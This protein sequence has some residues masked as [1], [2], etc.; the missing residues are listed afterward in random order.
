M[1]RAAQQGRP[2]ALTVARRASLVWLAMLGSAFVNGA[3]R[4]VVLM[5]T[6]ALPESRAQRVS[7]F[8]G[9]VLFTACV[10]GLWSYMRVRSLA[11]AVKIGAVWF[12][13][14]GLTEAFAINMYL[15]GQS[16]EQVLASYDVSKGKL[17]PLVLAWIGV[18]PVFVWYTQ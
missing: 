3:L 2:P 5:K 17:W 18:L 14:T 8:T 12:V 13:A 10:R 1:A 11:T 4:E 6:L 9:I 15:G 16:W 7:A